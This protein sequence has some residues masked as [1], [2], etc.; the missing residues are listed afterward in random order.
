M[1]TEAYEH[2]EGR[3]KMHIEAKLEKL[4][5]T[6]SEPPKIPSDVQIFF[7]L[8]FCSPGLTESTAKLHRIAVA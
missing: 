5:P 7:C 1:G 6:L 8:R 3:N 4:G 2:Q